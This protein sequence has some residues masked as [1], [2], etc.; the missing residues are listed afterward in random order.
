MRRDSITK[1]SPRRGGEGVVNADENS[2]AEKFKPSQIFEHWKRDLL[3]I[4]FACVAGFAL[5]FVIA[6]YVAVN[7]KSNSMSAATN[8]GTFWTTTSSSDCSSFPTEETCKFQTGCCWSLNRCIAIAV[9]CTRLQ[10][11]SFC[12]NAAPYCEWSGSNPKCLRL[13][14]VA[15]SRPTSSPLIPSWTTRVVTEKPSYRPTMAMS[16]AM[17][18]KTRFSSPGHAP[19]TFEPTFLPI[20]LELST[21]QSH[22]PSQSPS[23][24]STTTKQTKPTIAIP[25]KRPTRLPTRLPTSLRLLKTARP[26][27]LPTPLVTARAS[28]QPTKPQTDAPIMAPSLQLTETPTVYKRKTSLLVLL[29]D[30]LGYGDVSYNSAMGSFISTPNIDEMSRAPNTIRFDRFHSAGMSCS[31]SRAAMM[32]IRNSV[33]DCVNG[34]NSV[35]DKPNMPFK[36]DFR[37]QGYRNATLGAMAQRAGYKT[38]MF[39]KWHVSALKELHQ[40]GFSQSWGPVSGGN[41]PTFDNPCFYPYPNTKSCFAGHLDPTNLAPNFNPRLYTNSTGPGLIAMDPTPRFMPSSTRITDGFETFIRSLDKDDAFFVQL[42]FNEPHMPYF[43]GRATRALITQAFRDAKFVSTF[44]SRSADYYGSIYHMDAAVGR[45]RKLLKDLDRHQDTLVVF[46]S[47]NGPEEYSMGGAGSAGALR[48]KKRSLFE[49][50]H[51]VPGLIEWPEFI[52]KNQISLN[53]VSMLD[54]SATML[55]LVLGRSAYPKFASDNSID[56]V[57]MLDYFVDIKRNFSSLQSF[58]RAKPIVLCTQA[59]PPDTH[60]CRSLAVISG[61]I[62]LIANVST[63]N[64]GFLI[65]GTVFLYD[66][67]DEYNEVSAIYPQLRA[68]L[69]GFATTWIKTVVMQSLRKCVF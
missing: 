56:G 57:S 55:H 47:D 63:N 22:L 20:A 2:C 62:K 44:I 25:S 64:D 15:T 58:N 43:A 69:V 29:A 28:L 33:R 5:V 41:L 50:G 48:G 34:A 4:A 37:F 11:E 30:D 17:P 7:T 10:S 23:M 1:S 16:T 45:V 6:T 52:S 53:L 66:V 3:L 31:P 60:P 59:T 67:N 51:R 19:S 18:T 46:T 24:L 32:S 39:G 40:F 49:G 36:A 14:I 12:T 54:V 61:S 21:S 27:K 8:C 9:E 13:A 38:S 42:W 35:S 68:E 26:S 65:D